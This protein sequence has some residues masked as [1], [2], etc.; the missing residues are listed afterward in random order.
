MNLIQEWQCIVCH[1][2]QAMDRRSTPDGCICPSLTSLL[3]RI[4]PCLNSHRTSVET[5]DYSSALNYR[6]SKPDIWNCGPCS[7]VSQ[8]LQGGHN[9]ELALADPFP[10]CHPS[11]LPPSPPWPLAPVLQHFQFI[12]N[13]LQRAQTP[14]MGFDCCLYLN[15]HSEESVAWASPS[16]PPILHCQAWN[17]IINILRCSVPD[18]NRSCLQGHLPQLLNC[19]ENCNPHSRHIPRH[20]SSVLC[21]NALWVQTD[22]IEF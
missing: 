21:L 22:R 17:T 8:G 16:S 3:Q 7:G 11:L 2:V 20:I 10:H 19:T 9:R 5:S 14:L 12:H 4:Y 18:K 1:C 6:E 13:Q 15:K